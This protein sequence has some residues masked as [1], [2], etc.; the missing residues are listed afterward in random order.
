MESDPGVSERHVW[1]A[2]YLPL[3]EEVHAGP[4]SF[5]PFR[6]FRMR[7]ARSREVYGE[8]KRLITAY[9]LG[10]KL[11]R[12]GAVVRLTDG[13]VGDQTSPDDLPR[14]ERALAAALIDLNPSFLDEEDPN[15]GHISASADNARVFGYMLENR[16]SF[17]FA[18]GA[19]VRRVNLV[20]APPG[21]RLPRQ[22]PP[23]ALPQPI[24]KGYFDAEYA[25]ALYDAL[26]GDSQLAR[27]LDRCI[28]WLILAWTNTEA[29]GSDARILAFRAAFE[30]L[31]A[32]ESTGE[33]GRALSTLLD[34]PGD[35]CPRSWT[36]RGKTRERVLDDTEWWFQSFTLLRNAIAHGD[37]VASEQWLFDDGKLH[38]WHA[39]DRLRRAIKRTAIQAGADPAL[40]LHPFSRLIRRGLESAETDGRVDRDEGKSD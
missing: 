18:E 1:L 15:A 28:Q 40:E 14:L 38:L 33:C 25:G 20:S 36:D 12:L 2:P 39:D 31:L 34:D 35:R 3:S 9:K 27:Q 4:W 22:P 13:R 6:D 26:S 5:V 23:P 37:E 32:A 29:I 11:S 17:A 8:A 24:L 19:L 7:H 16:G 10:G 30:V 21:R